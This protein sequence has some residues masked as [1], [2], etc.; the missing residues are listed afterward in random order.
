MPGEWDEGVTQIRAPS[1]VESNRVLVADVDPRRRQWLREVLAGFFAVDEVDNARAALERLT[2]DPPRVLIVGTYLSDLS[3]ATLLA[4]AARYNLLAPAEHGP[5]AFYASNT[6]DPETAPPIDA[7]LV[8]IYYHLTP[9]LDPAR[10]RELIA[11]AIGEM[12]AE[13]AKPPSEEDAKLTRQVLEHAK[14]LGAQPDLAAAAQTVIAA[15]LDLVS[16][17]R[18]RCRFYDDETGTLWSEGGDAEPETHASL[19]ISGFAVRTRATIALPIAS[20]EAMYRR[21]IDDPQG[22]GNER[23]LIQPVVG[24]DGRVHAVL[25]VARIS[26]RPPFSEHE[27]KKLAALAEAW[28]PFIHQLALAQEADAVLEQREVVREDRQELFRREA[29]DHLIKRGMRGDVVRVHPGWIRSAYWIVMLALLGAGGFAY[30]AR[31]HEYA[32]GPAIVRI[33]GRSDVAAQE[34]GT[35][36]S[37]E[38]VPNQQVKQGQVIAR[39]HDT[40]QAARLHSLNTEFERHLVAY[41]Q[42]PADPNV[43]QALS[44][45]VTQRESA[46][47]G[48]EARVVRA[49]RDGTVKDVLVHTGQRVEPGKTIASIVDKGSDEGLAVLAFLPGRERPRLRGNQRMRLSLPGYRDVHFELT[50]RAV[51]SQVLGPSEARDLYLGDRFGDSVPL[52]QGVVVVEA[53][54]KSPT[55]VS[56][57]E[58]YELHDG[59]LGTAEVELASKSVVETLAPGL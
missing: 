29:I 32:E 31:I 35:V 12:P 59:M 27:A 4:H 43:R 42:T 18:V 58:R 14:R 19:G 22:T 56:D 53:R 10:T 20:S 48:V 7:E 1:F 24:R 54:I 57:G 28:A 21:E 47:A 33:T 17:E 41:L 6:D 49:P 26:T 15:V 45:L 52:Q 46:E 3:G 44:T 8:H 39:L 40:E 50:V 9:A 30:F 25:I 55:F 2:T 11:Q 38:V 13:R 51:S 36:T 37:I 23:L 16:A 34:A 5:I